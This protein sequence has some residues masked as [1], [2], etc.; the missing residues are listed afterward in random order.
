MIQEN[1]NDL[2]LIVYDSPSPPRCFRINKKVFKLVLILLSVLLIT[3]VMATLSLGTYT[4]VLQNKVQGVLPGPEIVEELREQVA[5]LSAQNE[6]LKNE[7]SELK[8]K[9][10]KT[11]EVTT[12]VV[13]LIV[14]KNTIAP[15]KPQ[16]PRPEDLIKFFKMPPGFKNLTSE[17]YA[18]TQ[19]PSY[20]VKT[21]KVIFRFNLANGKQ[22]KRLQGY[23]FVAQFTENSI[24]FYPALDMANNNFNAQFNLG[25]S[26]TVSRFRPTIATFDKPE[27]EKQVTYKILVFSRTGDL[28]I[29][30]TH[31]PYTLE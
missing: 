11:E 29:E 13:P 23:I 20:R 16:I 21:D 24:K 6:E 3:M 5:K 30:E 15:S 7:N 9:F 25:E 12:P 10:I 31:G 2:T 4:K 18:T 1:Q 14:E 27:T 8:T 17:G 19:R 26:F 22:V 28:L